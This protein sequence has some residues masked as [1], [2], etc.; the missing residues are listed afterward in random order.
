MKRKIGILAAVLLAIQ[1]IAPALQVQAYTSEPYPAIVTDETVDGDQFAPSMYDVT[2]LQ[3]A[4]DA[5][6]EAIALPDNEEAVRSAYEEVI[7]QTDE[8]FTVQAIDHVFYYA[9]VNDQDVVNIY[10]EM[11]VL[12]TEYS[13]LAAISLYELMN[14]DYAYLGEETMDSIN[15][16]YYRDYNA[17]TDRQ[18]EIS[19]RITELESEYNQLML[20]EINVTVNGQEWNDDSAYDAYQNSDIEY[21]DYQ[22]ILLEIAKIRN[23]KAG[24]IYKEM[25]DLHVE[26]AKEEGEDNYADWSYEVSYIR[27]YTTEDIKSV[28]AQVKEYIVPLF[29][30]LLAEMYTE[31]MYNQL[32]SLFYEFE[33]AYGDDLVAAVGD[34]IAQISPELGENFAFMQE[35]HLV[36]FDPDKKKTDV[37]F[38]TSLPS[39]GV[40]YIFYKPSESYYDYDVL[41]H[42]FGHYNH[43]LQYPEH[44]LTGNSNID[45]AEVHSQGLELLSL[46]KM[47]AVFGDAVDAYKL[48]VLINMLGS[49]TSGCLF[50]EFQ[51]AVYNNP[52]MTLDEMNA[53]F[54]QLACEYN[55]QDNYDCDEEAERCYSWV[56]VSHT[57]EVPMYYISYATSA[58]AALDIYSVYLDDPEEGLA[59]YEKAVEQTSDVK[60]R[61]FL[62]ACGLDDIFQDGVIEE[63]SRKI[64][65]SMA[66]ENTRLEEKPGRGDKE[67]SG[68]KS[69]NT[70]EEETDG[71]FFEQLSDS[72]GILPLIVLGVL[73]A[74]VLV[75][76]VVI[77]VA[78][79][80][81]KKTRDS[82]ANPPTDMPQQ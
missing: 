64:E 81:Q 71:T 32:Y 74:V 29:D 30:N 14:S 47:D 25:V 46:D 58:L 67:H 66:G 28:Y 20:E 21:E 79:K 49:V 51:V 43:E 50:D 53:L 10:Q 75:L 59:I 36:D 63:I 82:S 48:V 6:H 35:H 5:L 41:T 18:K 60:Y 42:E 4:I 68:S 13:D 31:D 19:S 52:D 33:P 34:C 80:H 3:A 69:E 70:D 26:D 78:L 22:A 61:A 76:I 37:G 8:M 27:D 44:A 16:E 1:S 23:E 55:I 2:A 65:D 73:V 62:Q 40:P 11:D 45:T 15:A 57:F 17:M 7:L 77:A 9:D 24:A 72:L 38:T 54:Y 12:T 39:Y 56:E